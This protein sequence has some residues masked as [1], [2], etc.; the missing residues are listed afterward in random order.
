MRSNLKT[1][2]LFSFVA[3][4]LATSANA[5][6]MGYPGGY[7]PYHG[8]HHVHHAYY[9]QGPHV[10]VFDPQAYPAPTPYPQAYQAENPYPTVASEPGPLI[11]AY[12]RTPSRINCLVG[13][14]VMYDD[15]F[16]G[17]GIFNACDGEWVR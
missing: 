2:A 7:A 13:R 12:R 10:I 16:S 1:A 4:G 3:L 14:P 6:D 8:Y 17:F 15:V 5:A 11:V 9:G